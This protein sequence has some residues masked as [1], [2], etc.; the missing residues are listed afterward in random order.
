M[1]NKRFWWSVI[2]VWAVLWVTD[3]LFHGVWLGE[4]YQQTAQYWRPRSEMMHYAPLMWVGNFIFAWA[5]VWIYSKGISKG[6]LWSQAFRYGLAIIGV[7][8]INALTAT[9][10][11]SPY[12]M[13]IIWKWALIWTVQAWLCAFVMTLTFNPK[14]AWAKN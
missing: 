4:L 11:S 3:F 1:S 12:P 6:N 10:A 5:F 14:A 2:A 8:K 7:S 13:E 9:F